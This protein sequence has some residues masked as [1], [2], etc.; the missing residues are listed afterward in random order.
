M[1][2]PLALDFHPSQFPNTVQDKLQTALEARQLP[3]RFLYDSPAQAA[4]WL[5]Y[6]EAW[7][8]S[9][10]EA[11]LLDLYDD[12]FRGGLDALGSRELGYVSLGCG[13]GTKDSRF[14]VQA[15]KRGLDPAIT[16]TD[17]SPSLVMAALLKNPEAKARGVVVD[18]EAEPERGLFAEARPTLWTAFG[19]VP[20]LDAERFLGWL[21]RCLEPP[22]I[23]LV[24]ANLHR[25]PWPEAGPEILPQ[26]DNREARAWYMG[27]LAELGLGA[28][29]LEVRGEPRGHNGAAWRV[30]VE[31]VSQAPA[32]LAV[33][34]RRIHL[35]A[36]A[37]ISV[38][39]S[40][41]FTAEAFERTLDAAGLSPE[42][43]WIFEGEEEGVWLV[44]RVR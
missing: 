39:Y 17:T 20:N 14:R 15:G 24:S 28:A 6:H 9:R 16:L 36:Q 4:R 43:R 40:N 3:A 44:R 1:T 32:E 21:G 34:D 2:K 19:M 11:E 23:A 30:K 10:T 25:S 33:S 8:P 18:L 26:Y 31:A 22:D 41:R 37:S 38:F 35:P 29:E 42:R 12:A 7:S 27:A 5:A 13:G